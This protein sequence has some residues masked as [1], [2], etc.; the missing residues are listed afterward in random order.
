[1]V[2]VW[3]VILSVVQVAEIGLFFWITQTLSRGTGEVLRGILDREQ[4]SL[5]LL[6]A[7]K[8]VIKYNEGVD[9]DVDEILLP[10]EPI[11]ENTNQPQNNK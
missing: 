2:I 10:R 7:I 5:K 4:N 3:L 6:R 11:N 8:Q 9:L 1:M